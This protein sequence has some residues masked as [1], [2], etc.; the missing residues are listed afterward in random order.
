MKFGLNLLDAWKF[1]K[2]YESKFGVGEVGKI[3]VLKFHKV[4]SSENFTLEFN[5]SKPR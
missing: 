1:S 5:Q 4:V 3:C 2:I